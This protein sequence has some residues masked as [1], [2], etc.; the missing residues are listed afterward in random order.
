MDAGLSTMTQLMDPCD[1]VSE[2]A[3]KVQKIDLWIWG[4]AT[5]STENWRKRDSRKSQKSLKSSRE[6]AQQ[7]KS[8]L[9]LKLSRS[10]SKTSQPSTKKKLITELRR[11]KTISNSEVSIREGRGVEGTNGRTLS[12]ENRVDGDK[13]QS[14]CS[15]DPFQTKRVSDAWEAGRWA[16]K[17]DDVKIGITE[18][19]KLKEVYKGEKDKLTKVASEL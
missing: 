8:R 13:I 11:R 19:G 6:T 17:E 10:S 14:I 15:S 18:L 16:E 1:F 12:A 9:G 4:Y 3:N 5:T 2:Y 7:Q